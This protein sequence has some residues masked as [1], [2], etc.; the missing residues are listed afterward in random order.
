MGKAF[1]GLPPDEAKAGRCLSDQQGQR[2]AL[3]KTPQVNDWFA[4][5]I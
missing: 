4:V 1:R 5:S 3:A 2:H